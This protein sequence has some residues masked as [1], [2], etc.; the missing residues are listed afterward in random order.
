MV[1][2]FR[3]FL[4]KAPTSPW[5]IWTVIGRRK[6]IPV[7]TEIL[8]ICFHTEAYALHVELAKLK[9]AA[10]TNAAASWGWRP[11]PRHFPENPPL[12]EYFSPVTLTGLPVGA[13]VLPVRP[14]RVLPTGNFIPSFTCHTVSLGQTS[15]STSAQN[16]ST[17][18]VFLLQCP[19][20][21]LRV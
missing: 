5:T 12:R 8:L 9:F 13:P 6:V 17:E 7:S 19:S 1:E 2:A 14:F 10:S 18:G 3:F 15:G 4:I 11:G 16:F 21:I 20:T